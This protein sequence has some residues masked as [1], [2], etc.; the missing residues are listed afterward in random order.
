MSV[1]SEHRREA[2]LKIL[3]NR[4]QIRNFYVIII[5]I[6]SHYYILLYVTEIWL[7]FHSIY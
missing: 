2:I 1:F 3:Q 5:N 7:L 6:L 4:F